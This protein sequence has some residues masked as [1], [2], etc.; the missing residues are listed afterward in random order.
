MTNNFEPLVGFGDL[1]V[2]EGC[3][4]SVLHTKAAMKLLSG[5]REK[6]TWAKLVWGKGFVPRFAFIL[7]L[8]CKKRL[9]TLDRLQ[10]WGVSLPSSLCILYNEEEERIHHMFFNCCTTRPVWTKVQHM[11]LVFRGSYSWDE[12]L[13]WLPAH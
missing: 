7:W 4:P 5:S 8:L 10:K 9:P 1:V 2:W 6:M 13:T 12:E 3:S 11:C